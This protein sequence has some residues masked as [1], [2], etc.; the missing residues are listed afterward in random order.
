MDWKKKQ[1]QPRL[2]DTAAA[3]GLS[4]DDDVAKTD[5]ALDWLEGTEDS[6]LPRFLFLSYL[7]PHTPYHCPEPYW[8]TYQNVI[9]PQPAKESLG[10]STKPRRQQFHAWNNDQILPFNTEQV[11]LMQRTYAGQISLIDHEVGRVLD[12][13]EN[14]GREALFVFTSDHGDY[15]GDHGLFTKSPALYDLSGSGTDAGCLS[16]AIP[17]G[18]TCDAAINHIDLMPSL[19][20]AGADIPTSCDGESW[21]PLLCG[22]GVAW[23]PANPLSYGIPGDPQVPAPP[24]QK[25]ISTVT[26]MELRCHGEGESAKPW[27]RSVVYEHRIGSLL[28]TNMVTMSCMIWFMIDMNS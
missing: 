10:L 21:L 13:I 28:K 20:A 23:R 15:Q 24:G 3:G 18:S 7:A 14:S 12:A 16:G 19:A 27:W 25:L 22:A 26:L 5:V 9:L 11:A 8:S 17:A 4:G 2:G 6:A 1:S